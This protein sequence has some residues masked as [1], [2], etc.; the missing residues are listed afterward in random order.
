MNTER[1]KGETS[2]SFFATFYTTRSI[3]PHRHSV[4]KSS[5][6][7]STAC[8][9]G[10][11]NLTLLCRAVN[12]NPARKIVSVPT[13][14]TMFLCKGFLRNSYFAGMYDENVIHKITIIPISVAVNASALF[15][16]LLIIPS[17]NNP[18]IPPAKMP[19]SSH[20]MSSKLFTPIIAIPVI[21]PNSPNTIVAACSVNSLLFSERLGLKYLL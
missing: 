5:V 2:S 6:T 15:V 1:K 8:S 14:I 10:R 11:V 7:V 13:T 9:F 3:K 21:N 12:N 19:D 20:Q 4:Q 18:S 17:K 16:R